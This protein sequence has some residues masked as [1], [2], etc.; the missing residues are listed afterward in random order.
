MCR[1]WKPVVVAGDDD[2][3]TETMLLECRRFHD[4]P[5]IKT[6][7]IRSRNKVTRSQAAIVR[8]E[9]GKLLLPE[10][11]SHKVDDDDW[12][13]T[14]CDQLSSFTGA[15]GEPDDLADTVAILGRLADE[16]RP[17]EADMDE[18]P[19]DPVGGYAG[20]DGGW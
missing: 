10:N 2:N 6:L 7:G 13:D 11:T 16:F 12:M 3:L 15:D 9:R 1:R 20:I 4:I 18:D 5:T 17:G 14:L 19:A 8:A